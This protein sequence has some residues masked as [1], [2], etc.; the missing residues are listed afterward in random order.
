MLRI[1][2]QA[3]WRDLLMASVSVAALSIAA[4]A[5]AQDEEPA[6]PSAEEAA[7]AAAEEEDTIVVTGSR[8]R[9]DEF[10]STAPVQIIDPS[11]GEL[12]G[13]VDTAELIQ[14]SSVAAGSVQITSAI[15]SAF[16][17]NGG[18]GTQT[19]SLRGLGAERTLV[20]LNGRRAGPAGVRGAVSAFDLNVLPQSV[21]STIEVLKDGASSIYG[22]DAV[23]GVVNIITKTDTDGIDLNTFYSQP[24]KSGGEEFRASATYGKTFSRGHFQVS[25]DYYRRWELK[26]GDREYLACPEEYIFNEDGT[27]RADIVDPRTGSYA[28]R[29]TLWGHIWL[30]DYTYYYS[31]NGSN[32]VAPNGNPIRRLQW[33]Y[34]GDNLGSHIPGVTPPVDPFQFEVPEGWFPVGYDA[35]SFAVENAYHPFI[36]A[37]TVIPTT[38]RYTAYADGAF[39]ATDWAELYTEVLFNRRETE[40][41]SFRQFWQFGFTENFVPGF[42]DPFAD[43][44]N[45]AVLISPTPITD[46][47]GSSQ[48]VDYYRVVGGARGE[49]G[50]FLDDWQWDLHSQYSRSDGDYTRE[51][52]LDDAV[53]SQDFRTGSCVGETLPIS[54]RPCIDVDWLD[55]EFLAGNI[56]PE[57]RAF[58]F[59]EETG[60][61]VY[62]QWTVEGIVTGDLFSLPAGD[63]GLAL[64]GTWRRDEIE[65]VPGPITRAGNA[66]GVTTAGITAGASKTTEG[67]GEIQVPLIRDLPLIQNLLLQ[68]AGRYTHVDT[69]GSDWTYKA[70][71]SWQVNDWLRFRGTYGTSFR[72]PALFELFLADQTSF[73]SQRQVDPCINWGPNLANGVIS[74]QLADNCAADGVPPNHTGAGITATVITG[75]GFGLLEAETSDAMTVSMVLTPDWFSDKTNLRIALDYFE[76]EVNGEIAR[77]GAGNVVAGCYTSDFFPNDPLCDLFSRNPPVGDPNNIDFVRDSFLNIHSQKNT[78]LDATIQLD[79]DLPPGLGT[80]SLLG[81]MTWQFKDTVALFEATETSVNGEAG[82]PKWVGDF[83]I[84]WRLDGWSVFY[85]IDA[86]SGTSDEQ[87]Y[88]DAN[89]TLCPTDSIHGTFCVDLKAE[90]RIYHSFSVTK[91]FETWKLTLGVANLGDTPP[92]RVSTSNRGEISTIGQVPFTSNYDFVGRRIFFNVGKTF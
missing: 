13:I 1:V 27:E 81:Q 42:G 9:Q 19:I 69:Y 90:H 55:P 47:F 68:G 24:F 35:A 91:E 39:Q 50:S 83:N 20:L 5:V 92:P 48:K 33:D 49:F 79:Q 51:Q 62:T 7:A 41:N 82:E 17:T 2:K 28:C 37:A 65:D 12:Q 74:Q 63:V 88:I 86:L 31:P 21:I 70:G 73:L 40:Q 32:L 87:D 60:N 64:G 84:V 57:V 38:Q 75:G 58:L 14:S 10:T 8:I 4:P 25:A 43:G 23:A 72:A 54:G 34:A 61:T 45:G 36:D 89:G 56:S 44:F 15:S 46:H 6:V 11:I 67:F 30:Y 52:I 71:A 80:I 85:G 16:V 59:D 78:G 3:E 29:D 53:S 76:I 77:L 66:W 26:R 18:A 22:S